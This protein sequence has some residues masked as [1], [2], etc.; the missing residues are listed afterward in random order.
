MHRS[1]SLSPTR[2]SDRS[3]P[4]CS[5]L[6]RTPPPQSN[7]GGRSHN[8]FLQRRVLRRPRSKTTCSAHACRARRAEANNT[9]TLHIQKLLVHVLRL[10]RQVHASLLRAPAATSAL[11]FARTVVC[12]LTETQVRAQPERNLFS[13]VCSQHVVIWGMWRWALGRSWSVLTVPAPCLVCCVLRRNE[14]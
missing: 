2:C 9:A 11:Y 13:R 14:R 5:D 3:S 4:S 6:V 12:H 1:R 8:H 10:V 7:D